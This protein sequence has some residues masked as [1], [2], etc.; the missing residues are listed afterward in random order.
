MWLLAS[1]TQSMPGVREP[2]D[3]VGI[4]GEHRA[5]DVPVAELFGAGFSKLAIARSAPLDQ[6]AHRPALP[7][8]SVCGSSQPNAEQQ[9]SGR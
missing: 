9:V 6:V 3:Q 4:G 5:A 1:D 8:R 7:V 2:V